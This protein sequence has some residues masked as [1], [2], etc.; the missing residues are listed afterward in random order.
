MKVVL[1]AGTREPI[2]QNFS[3]VFS[4]DVIAEVALTTP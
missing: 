2:G 3:C 1:A 4:G